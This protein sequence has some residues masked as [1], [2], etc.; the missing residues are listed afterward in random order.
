M[1]TAF[2]VVVGDVPST[3][4]NLKWP[5][6]ESCATRSFITLPRDARIG[7]G[8]KHTIC[9]LLLP[10][11]PPD[12]VSSNIVQSVHNVIAVSSPSTV[13]RRSN[14]M[15]SSKHLFSR[16]SATSSD[17]CISSVSSVTAVCFT[18]RKRT[19]S[20]GD[21]PLNRLNAPRSN[22]DTTPTRALT[23]S[24]CAGML[25]PTARMLTFDGSI[26]ASDASKCSQASRTDSNAL[27]TLAI[28]SRPGT[29]NTPAQLP[30]PPTGALGF[31][32]KTPALEGI[33][34]TAPSRLF[35]PMTDR[36]ADA[37]GRLGSSTCTTR[38]GSP[39]SRIEAAA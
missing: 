25:T 28:S 31:G 13:A 36:S 11:S 18:S 4:E 34:R 32:R 7:E 35:S 33:K 24:V 15:P 3:G 27:P 19:R 9:R 5:D 23:T 17:A 12:N 8:R 29:S 2:S 37:M 26:A 21:S 6:E 14:S 16:T 10:S 22:P 20:T 38:V 30:N 1:L 39:S